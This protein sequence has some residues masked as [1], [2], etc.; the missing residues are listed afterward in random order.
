MRRNKGEYVVK[1]EDSVQTISEQKTREFKGGLIKGILIWIVYFSYGLIAV[2]AIVKGV[3]RFPE[4]MIGMTL[5]T[6]LLNIVPITTFFV[7]A[8]RYRKNLISKLELGSGYKSIVIS[9]LAAALY[10]YMYLDAK[11]GIEDN[12]VLYEWLYYLLG[13][14]FLEE[15][16]F[17]VILPTMISD[18]CGNLLAVVISNFL[19]AIL[20]LVVPIATEMSSM[21]FVDYINC[22][23][24]PFLLGLMFSGLK[25][26][27]GS[28][29][30]GIFFHAAIDFFK[31]FR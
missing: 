12:H 20:H 27:F 11:L 16:L 19:F 2:F 6:I 21:H 5:R 17:R 15:M 3:I 30:P 22:V 1:P 31:H 13:V 26:C 7:V 28:V 18:S 24:G 23:L 8:I 29:V 9:F 10:Y 4:T 25:I 14:A